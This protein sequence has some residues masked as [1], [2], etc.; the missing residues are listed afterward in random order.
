MF[1]VTSFNSS[2][3]LDHEYLRRLFR[4]ISATSAAGVQVARL[5]LHDRPADRWRDGARDPHRLVHRILFRLWQGSFSGHWWSP[6][7]FFWVRGGS[8]HNHWRYSSWCSNIFLWT[9]VTVISESEKS[10]KNKKIYSN[11]LVYSAIGRRYK[12]QLKWKCVSEKFKWRFFEKLI[13]CVSTLF[14]S[15]SLKANAAGCQLNQVLTPDLAYAAYVTFFHLVM[16]C[17]LKCFKNG[18]FPASFFF[19]SVFSIHSWQLTNVQYTNKFL[20]MTGFEP[21]TSGIGSSR[22]TNWATTTAQ[23]FKMFTFILNHWIISKHSVF[24]YII[25][26]TSNAFKIVPKYLVPLSMPNT[27]RQKCWIRVKHFLDGPC[28]SGLQHSK[29]EPPSPALLAFQWA[30]HDQ[31]RDVRT[32]PDRQP[33]AAGLKTLHYVNCFGRV[34]PFQLPLFSPFV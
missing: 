14:S 29:L 10:K 6:G 12:Q 19:I 13:K 9:A 30:Q 1:N 33:A 31:G 4:R 23:L 5:C 18:P 24:I 20:P 11:C 34:A 22:S 28:A 2:S 21:R 3:R 27:F 15:S 16:I 32:F 7:T 17:F 8:I 26:F 25:C